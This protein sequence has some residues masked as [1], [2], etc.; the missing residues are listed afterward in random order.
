MTELK[1]ILRWLGRAAI[2]Q[3]TLIFLIHIA[4]TKR[5]GNLGN[6]VT[7][8]LT[9]IHVTTKQVDIVNGAFSSIC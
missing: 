7:H 5:L 6:N 4:V 3:S 9:K 1:T 8:E 2:L